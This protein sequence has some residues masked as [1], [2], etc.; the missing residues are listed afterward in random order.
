MTSV[1][2]LVLRSA[3]TTRFGAAANG[4]Y[5]PAYVLGNLVFVQLGAGIAML[6]ERWRGGT[7]LQR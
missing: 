1:V 2:D 6:P 5:Q 4:V 7:T 3:L